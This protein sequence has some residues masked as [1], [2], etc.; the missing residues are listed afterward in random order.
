MEVEKIKTMVPAEELKTSLETRKAVK[1]IVDNA[2][3]T[4][5]KAK[6]TTKK[7]AEKTEA[8]ETEEKTEKPKRTKKAVKTEE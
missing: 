2:K 1:V 4:A 7:A 6:K 8:V 5:P 3:A